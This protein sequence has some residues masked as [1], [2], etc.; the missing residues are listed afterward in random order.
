MPDLVV[1]LASGVVGAVLGQLLSTLPAR[2]AARGQAL[3]AVNVAELERIAFHLPSKY[4][5]AYGDA[6][7]ELHTECL[8]ARISP[9]ALRS[10]LILASVAY[11]TSRALKQEGNYRQHLTPVAD[12]EWENLV[13]K[14]ATLLRDLLLQPWISRIRFKRRR[15]INMLRD[16]ESYLDYR[17]PEDDDEP[18]NL[19]ESY[20]ML[21]FRYEHIRDSYSS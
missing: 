19:G 4:E 14:A 15:L 7:R 21:R 9:K 3:R 2:R 6:T 12:V 11:T 13:N 5:F 18:Y 17:E 8:I 10:Y 16:A 20:V 1:A